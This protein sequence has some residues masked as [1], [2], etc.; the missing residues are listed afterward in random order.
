MSRCPNCSGEN[1][2]TQRFCGECGTPL[3]ASRAAAATRS[4]EGGTPPDGP[5]ADGLLPG[6]LFARRYQV[7][8]EL[9]AGGMGRVFRVLDRKLDEEIALKLIRPE[10][11]SDRSSLARFSSELKLARQVVH[12]NV[13]RMFDLNEEGRVPF[14]TMEYVRGENLKRLIRKVGRLSPG[15]AIPVACQICDGLAEAHRLGIGLALLITS[16]AE[17]GP[18]SR[19]GTPAYLSPEQ[20]RG[21]PADAR[22]D[23]YSLGVLLYEALTG[24]TPFHAESAAELAAKHVREAPHDPRE[25]SRGISP[26]L[27]SVVLKCLEKDPAKRH[28]SAGELRADLE[29]LRAQLPHRVVLDWALRHKTVPISAGAALLGLV[30]YGGYLLLVAPPA[31][32]SPASTI[33]VL[34][35]P[36]APAASSAAGRLQDALSTGLAGIPE[37]VVVPPITVNSRDIAGRDPKAIGR[38]L[39]ADYLLEPGLHVQGERIGLTARLINAR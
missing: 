23:L 4:Y 19:S 34:R 14:I 10:V 7:I 2:D 25:H 11:A 21:A 16:Q 32:P 39:G 29:R 22:S 13:A 12:R 24:T 5:A 35:A 17:D 37:L 3:P 27:A 1:S 9:G 15:Q 8:E 31:P 6:A 18:G 28:Q 38:R 36:P 33:A 20:A 30:G 26:E